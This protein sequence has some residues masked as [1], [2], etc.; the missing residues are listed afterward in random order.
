MILARTQIS[1]FKKDKKSNVLI[2]TDVEKINL[3]KSRR[4]IYKEQK[5]L[6]TRIDQLE[7]RLLEISNRT[8]TL[9][10]IIE[11]NA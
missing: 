9:E 4:K 6:E 5:S 3:A 11:A 1:G 2:N 7:K 10:E 8:A